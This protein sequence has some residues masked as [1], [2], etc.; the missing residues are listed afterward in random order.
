MAAYGALV[1]VMHIIDQIQTLP[2][3]PISIDQ[4]QVESLTQLITSL[5]KFLESY[6]PHGGYTEEE[7]VWECRIAEA[8]YEAEDVIESYIVDQIS[9]R[10]EHLSSPEFYQGLE[11]VIENMNLIKIEI[12]EK[13]V[14][15]DQLHIVKSVYT[16][17]ADDDAASLR[18][19]S[20]AHRVT[21]V[22]FDDVLDQML[23]KITGG[24][25]KRQ[26]LPIVG[27]GG[28]GKTTLARNIYVSPLVQQHFNVCAWS[29]ISQ[30]YNA[31]EIL[32]QVPSHGDG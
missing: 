21:M 15:Q 16:A 26:I 28:I 4:N 8:A 13:M 14:L 30:D 32:R 25:L 3:S 10:S 5:Q 18:S 11:K 27:M 29:A 24:G 22:G 1:S 31:R 20:A 2:N 19:V 17:A 6:F 12:D 9:A 7:D 23:D